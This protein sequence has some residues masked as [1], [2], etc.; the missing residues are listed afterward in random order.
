MKRMIFLLVLG[1]LAIGSVLMAQTLNGRLATSVYGWERQDTIGQSSQHLRGYENIQ[2]NFGTSDI[3]FHSYMQGSTD[4]SQSI[5][6]DPQ[7]RLFNAYVQLKNIADIADIRLGRQAIF[8]GVSYGTIDGA[9]INVRPKDGVEVSAYGGGLSPASQKADFFQNLDQNWQIGGQVL[10]YLVENVKLGLSYMNRHRESTPF[11]SFRYDSQ[12]GMLPATI[13]YG[14]RANQYGSINAAY[15]KEKLWLFARFDYDFNFEKASRAEISGSYQIMPTLGLSLSFAH[16][17]P[18]IA[19]NSYF[20]ILEMEANQEVTVGVDYQLHDYLTLLGRF[21]NVIYDGDNAMRV[22]LGASNKYSSFFY[23]KDVSYDGNL[24]GLNFQ[25]T[26]PLME[27]QLVPH[28]GAVY[29]SYALADNLDKIA[30]WAGVIGTM[31]RPAKILSCDVQAQFMSNKLYKSDM[32]V[33]ARIS[34]WF[35]E[36]FGLG[37]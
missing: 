27:G 18:T 21:S 29:S 32:R 2:L 10:V 19:Y 8:A 25:L 6:N 7:L 12:L 9:M 33:F 34:Y 23:T 13:D 26:Y 3:S 30:T 28:V 15:M 20:S 5:E 17:E 24:D 22:S 4:F 14:S 11:E 36:T 31:F 37:V 16:R 1:V 35:A